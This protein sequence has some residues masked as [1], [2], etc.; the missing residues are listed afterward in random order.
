MSQDPATRTEVRY[1]AWNWDELPSA[2]GAAFAEERTVDK[3]GGLIA[4]RR[5][6]LG[7]RARTVS[8]DPRAAAIMRE[9]LGVRDPLGTMG[10]PAWARKGRG[11]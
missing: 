4:R 9:E 3:D 8:T 10:A 11:P 5:L 1:Y 7:N 6:P 2:T